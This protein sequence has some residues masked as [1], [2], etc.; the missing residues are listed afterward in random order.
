MKILNTKLTLYTAQLWE[1][2]YDFA[3]KLGAELCLETRGPTYI[4]LITTFLSGDKICSEHHFDLTQLTRIKDIE[5]YASCIK[6]QLI[7]QTVELIENQIRDQIDPPEPFVDTDS[8]FRGQS[9]YVK[10]TGSRK[11]DRENAER[12]KRWYDQKFSDCMRT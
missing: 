10:S 12:F 7:Q 9:I 5:D 8:Y 3:D 6:E 11:R 2:L 1:F 4:R